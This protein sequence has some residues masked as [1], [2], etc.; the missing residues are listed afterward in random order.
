MIVV[1][2]VIGLVVLCV[3]YP[4]LASVLLVVVIMFGVARLLGWHGKRVVGKRW[5]D[6]R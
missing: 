2:V 4:Q 6:R 5:G 1:L 3:E